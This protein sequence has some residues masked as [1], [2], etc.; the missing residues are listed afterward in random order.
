[1][2]VC[3]NHS[4]GSEGCGVDWQDLNNKIQAVTS[5]VAKV[6]AS[7]QFYG[8]S[9][10]TCIEHRHAED[11]PRKPVTLMWMCPGLG[12]GSAAASAASA[13]SASGEEGVL[14]DPR[15]H[16]ALLRSHFKHYDILLR[17]DPGCWSCVVNTSRSRDP[18]SPISTPRRRFV[19]WPNAF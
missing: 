16:E 4:G 3:G 10:F 19:V 18:S 17:K 13:S 2:D 12:V 9:F 1:M 7:P 8:D 15:D 6:V 11:R 14:A 5:F